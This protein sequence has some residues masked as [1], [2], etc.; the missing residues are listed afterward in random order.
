[1]TST[2]SRN[3][4]LASKI[5]QLEHQICQLK[6]RTEP[7]LESPPLRTE[8]GQLVERVRRAEQRLSELLELEKKRSGLLSAELKE[9][10]LLFQGMERE[11]SGLTERVGLAEGQSKSL[12]GQF[13]T[14]AAKLQEAVEEKGTLVVSHVFDCRHLII[15]SQHIFLPKLFYTCI[16]P[17]LS[18][19]LPLSLPLSIP[20][21][22]PPSL[23]LTPSLPHLFS[24]KEPSSTARDN[25]ERERD[26]TS[27]NNR[28]TTE[29][30]HSSQYN[31]VH[32]LYC[33]LHVLYTYTYCICTCI[34]ALPAVSPGT[35]IF[36]MC[37]SNS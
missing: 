21:S 18:P 29:V 27:G 12:V 24:N 32:I 13:Q 16:S 2:S 35:K 10:D 23:S 17:S 4:S 19:S 9:R 22:L 11:F 1:M 20:P 5:S 26:Q 34:H 8:G 7:L 3:A 33:L 37:Y 15:H 28:T 6:T 25:S 36:V 31:H 30:E 14:M